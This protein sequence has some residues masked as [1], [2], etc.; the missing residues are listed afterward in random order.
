MGWAGLVLLG[1]LVMEGY[2]LKVTFKEP[3]EGDEGSSPVHIWEKSI[4]SGGNS[5]YTGPERATCPGCWSTV[6]TPLW[7]E[8]TKQE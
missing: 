1:R 2:T 7:L 5:K 4:P 3:C 8:W 6:R